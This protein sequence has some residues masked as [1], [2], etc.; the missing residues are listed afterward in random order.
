MSRIPLCSDVAEMVGPFAEAVENRSLLLDKF[1]FHKKWG[2]DGVKHDDAL[3]WSLLRIAERGSGAL[4]AEAERRLRL[5]DTAEEQQKHEALRQEA[6]LIKRLASS[7]AESRDAQTLRQ[8]HSRRLRSLV[9]DAFRHD[10]FCV[11]ARL[12]SRLAIN[13]SDGLIQNAGIC[14]DRLFGLPY[15]PGSAVKGATRH[16]ALCELASA[17]GAD[18]A[19][20]LSAFIEVFGTAETDFKQNGDLAAF[21]VQSQGDQSLDRKGAISFLPAYPVTEAKVVV[22]LVNVHY[23][24]YYQ[25][26]EVSDLAIERPQ[27][28]PFPAV[29]R[30]AAFAFIAVLNGVSGDR[31]ALANAKRWLEK[32][33]MENGIGAKTGAGY[34]WFQLAPDL[35]EEIVQEAAKIRETAQKQAEAKAVAEAAS[36]VEEKRR[37]ELDPIALAQE[38]LLKL[39]DE[40]FAAFAKTL[41]EKSVEQQKAFLNLLRES[42]SKR[43]RRKTWKKKKPDLAKGIQSVN[44]T[45][46]LPP[47]P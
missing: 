32:A 44:K 1:V 27:P 36:R 7:R 41:G 2:L 30:G 42:R 10:A 31:S 47:L 8:Q 5:S 46:N 12:E 19:K 20:S 9:L 17:T 25:S 15:I 23:P 28:N 13:I 29:E 43:D 24:T 37:A 21:R 33:I 14:L 45:L 3:R 35:E 6:D 11:V 26:G 40:E 16:A 4:A 34:G 18:L 22:D 38:D 39:G